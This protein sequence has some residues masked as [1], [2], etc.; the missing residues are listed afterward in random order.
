[1]TETF[2]YTSS[3]QLKNLRVGFFITAFLINLYNFEYIHGPIISWYPSGLLSELF[4]LIN[5]ADVKF[6]HTSLKI[7]FLLSLIWGA[8]GFATRI[9]CAASAL[10]GYLFYEMHYEIYGIRHAD[11]SL[12]LSLIVCVFIPWPKNK[13]NKSEILNANTVW[14]VRTISIIPF[15]F[16]ALS[17]IREGGQ[18]WINGEALRS[19][20]QWTQLAFSNQPTFVFHGELNKFLIESSNYILIPVSISVVLFQI[21]APLMLFFKKTRIMGVVGLMLFIV[22]SHILMFVWFINAVPPLFFWLISDINKY[23]GSR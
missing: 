6:Y 21:I 8:S 19:N 10:F 18:D 23:K 13:L 12:I 2:F 1:M 7:F 16:A 5:V 22:I 20:L 11:A 3:L 15:I 9:A 14:I 4:I 17:K